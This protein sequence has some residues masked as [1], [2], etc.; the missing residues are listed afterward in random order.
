MAAAGATTLDEKENLD[1]VDDVGI[2][3][4]GN[5]ERPARRNDVGEAEDNE[6]AYLSSDDIEDF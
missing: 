1:D 5:G 6:G 4:P 2:G 3:V